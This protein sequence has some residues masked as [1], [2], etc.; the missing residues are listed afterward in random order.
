MLVFSLSFVFMY[1]KLE[2]F[3]DALSLLLTAGLS[4]IIFFTS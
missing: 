1:Q 2:T 3:S 4:F